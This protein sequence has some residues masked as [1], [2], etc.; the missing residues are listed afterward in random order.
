EESERTHSL[1]EAEF[2]LKKALDNA[3]DDHTEL[4]AHEKIGHFLFRSRRYAEAEP[5]FEKMEE[6]YQSTGQCRGLLIV[7]VNRIAATL[8]RGQ[9]SARDAVKRLEVC[10]YEAEE[11]GEHRLISQVVRQ[12]INAAHSES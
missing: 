8:H 12:V 4:L 5:H 3:Y 10:V 7:E 6:Y 2:Y 11:V 1:V 9:I